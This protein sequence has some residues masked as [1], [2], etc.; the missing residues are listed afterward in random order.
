MLRGGE[1][2]SHVVPNGTLKRK[3]TDT[4]TSRPATRLDAVPIDE[5]H[6]LICVGF[7]PASLAIIIALHDAMESPSNTSFKPKVCF[8]E[9]Q[10]E[11]RWHSGMMLPDA[12]MQI[13]FLKDLAM[14]RDPTSRFTFLNYLK[15]K[16][17]LVQFTN[18]S[19]FLPTRLEFADYMKWC[20]LAFTDVVE[21]GKEVV[22]VEPAKIEENAVKYDLLSVQ[23]RD[24]NGELTT[25]QTRNLVIAVGGRPQLPAFL[26]ENHSR[27]MH[28]S[29]YASQIPDVLKSRDK[30]YNIGVLGS[31]Q[32]AAEVFNDLHTR[33]PNAHTH[34][35]F[36]D[37]AL[38]PS[39]DSPF[40]NEIF[41]DDRIT[42][43]FNQPATARQHAITA[44]KSTNYSVVRG[45]LLEKI[46]SDL[47]QQRVL[48]ADQSLH[49]HKLHPS[50]EVA[51]IIDIPQNKRINVVL[52]NLAASAGTKSSEM[53]LNLDCLIYATGYVRDT[54]KTLLQGCQVI[55]ASSTGNWEVGR[56][57]RVKLD[58]G[59]VDEDV[60]IFLQ[61]CNEAS[62]GL[63]D[64]LISVLATRGG[65]VVKS[66]F[67]ERLRKAGEDAV[68]VNGKA[69]ER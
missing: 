8:L 13:S 1:G 19:T 17:R 68:K 66:I 52:K 39:D 2:T 38:R 45:E 65:E 3:H 6:D 47:Y 26:P 9:Q 46:Y 57:Y 49:K 35:I 12:K 34:L 60:S 28:S 29:V 30:A 58:G 63:S 20:S 24:A 54:H 62:H 21:Y 44:D 67:G 10:P 14:Q 55:N 64:S 31:G 36:R 27:V 69:G 5:I 41:D 59:F 22:K 32:S 4:I 33:F 18:L 23:A 40:V 25:R 11:F 48:E 51:E 42:P 56:D 16:D 61:G 50:T 43:F 37:S 7:G 15:V 53:M